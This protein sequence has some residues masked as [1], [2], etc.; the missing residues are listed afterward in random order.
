MCVIIISVSLLHIFNMSFKSISS[1]S[2]V[3][4]EV[5]D[6]RGGGER[7]ERMGGMGLN[8]YHQDPFMWALDRATRID[9]VLIR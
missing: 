8:P 4:Y 7:R 3:S 9:E 6:A 5:E 2:L 1:C